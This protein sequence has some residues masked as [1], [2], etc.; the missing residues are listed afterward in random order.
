MIKAHSFHIPVMGTS[1]TV[2]TPFKVAH[3]GIDS[4]IALNDDLLLEKLRK[5]YC[6]KFKIDHHFFEKSEHD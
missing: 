1:F 2:D 5:M 4:V 6:G 3:F